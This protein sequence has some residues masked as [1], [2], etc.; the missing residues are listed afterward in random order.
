MDTSKFTRYGNLHGPYLPDISLSLVT[1]AK[2]NTDSLIAV[3]RINIHYQI[4]HVMLHQKSYS[5]VYM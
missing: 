3:S 2:A 5:F 1:Q 4:T